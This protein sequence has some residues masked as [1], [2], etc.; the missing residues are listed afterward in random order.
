[1]GAA[2]EVETIF[3][4]TG[5]AVHVA[6]MVMSQPAMQPAPF[7][8][9]LIRAMETIRLADYQAEWLDQLRGA[10]SDSVNFC[11]LTGDEVRAQCVMI[12]QAVTHLPDAERWALQAKYGYVEYEDVG[13]EEMTGKQLVDAHKRALA[14]V[15]EGREKLRLARRD[16]DE[17]REQHLQ[18]EGRIAPA[19]VAQSV[20][21]RYFVARDDVRDAGAILARA[22][23]TE[24]Q[25]RIV[26][27]RVQGK[28]VTDGVAPAVGAGGRRFAF[29]SERI[30]AIKGLSDWFRPMFP[31]IKPF[32]IDCMLGR[33]FANHTKM[34]ISFADIATSFGGNAKLYERASFKM[35]NHLRELE[36]QAMDR[37]DKRLV[38]HGV[39]KSKESD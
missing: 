31:R 22:E 1:M 23:S 19:G 39:S 20:R 24:R 38:Q 30:D 15:A 35:R 36:K 13:P 32:A 17:A 25:I 34:G 26:V 18:Y 2:Q 7:R 27:D 4:S 9:A 3:A 28:T 16:L 5:Q 14:D 10:P 33:L 21:D 8:K 37:L 29:S 12:L 11:G 6:F